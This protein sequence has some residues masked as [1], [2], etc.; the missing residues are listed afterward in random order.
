MNWL[1]PAIG[2][3]GSFLGGKSRDKAAAEQNQQSYA[4]QDKWN[5]EQLDFA[6]KQHYWNQRVA[7]QSIRWRVRDAKNAGLHPL[8]ALGASSGSPSNVSFIPGQAPTGNAVGSGMANAME[9]IAGAA[10]DYIGSQVGRKKVDKAQ[11]V[12]DRI[13]QR[14]YRDAQLRSMEAQAA[15]DEISAAKAASDVKRAEQ[16]ANVSRGPAQPGS[17]DFEAAVK[18]KVRKKH[19][20][21]LAELAPG[22]RRKTISV[23]KNKVIHLNPHWTSGQAVE[24]EWGDLGSIPY[25]FARSIADLLWSID[26]RR[27]NEDVKH[28]RR[29]KTKKW[30]NKQRFMEGIYG[31]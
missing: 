30:R 8:Y 5:T 7:K 26:Q 23:G 11:E 22:P 14:R 24:D 18:Q 4:F 21:R 27:M 2:A 29:R 9:N 12:N 13:Y 17:D 10:G 6:K 1:G 19:I 20:D 15:H 25:S 28:S 16:S 3:I 31:P